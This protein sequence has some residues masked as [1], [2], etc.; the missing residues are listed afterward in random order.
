LLLVLGLLA[1]WVMV[2]LIPWKRVRWARVYEEGLKW[3][4]GRREYKYRWDE[5]SDVNRTEMEFM[6][7]EGRRSTASRVASVSLRF[8]DGT[9]VSFTPALKDYTKLATY[10]QQAVTASQLAE[11]RGKLD[12][13]GKGF[14]PVHISRKG[15]TAHGKFFAWKEVRWLAVH[16]GELCA[17]HEC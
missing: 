10:V 9:G 7:H 17:H 8:A 11:S 12:E 4:A 2:L 3:K 15:V 16:N 13:A 6:G 14:G 5:V 1:T